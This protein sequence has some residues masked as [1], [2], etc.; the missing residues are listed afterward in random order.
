MP[1]ESATVYGLRLRER[2]VDSWW[3]TSGLVFCK[4]WE[5]NEH[6]RCRH[7]IGKFMNSA[8]TF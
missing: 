2:E 4:T 1:V 7:L 5:S 6:N 8:G 3:G